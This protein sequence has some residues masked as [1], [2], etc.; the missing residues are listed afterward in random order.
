MYLTLLRLYLEA[1]E[2][3]ILYLGLIVLLLTSWGL[4][5]GAITDIAIRVFD[6]RDA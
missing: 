3:P 1:A 2:N 5:V 6:V 4:I